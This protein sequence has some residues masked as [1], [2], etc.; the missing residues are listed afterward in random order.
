MDLWTPSEED[1]ESFYSWTKKTDAW[2]Q[3]TKD[4]V[5]PPTLVNTSS[6]QSFLNSYRAPGNEYNV[7]NYLQLWLQLHKRDSNFFDSA[8]DDALDD[9]RVSIWRY[10]DSNG[11]P[12]KGI[13]SPSTNTYRL[14]YQYI[15]FAP[16]AWQVLLAEPAPPPAP[17]LTNN[18][19]KAL[20]AFAG[21]LEATQEFVPD[22]WS[23]PDIQMEPDNS[24]LEEKSW[25]KQKIW[26]RSLGETVAASRKALQT[27]LRP[28]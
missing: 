4:G 3:F 16:V 1:W 25:K 7:M 23:S 8:F 18:E 20:K 27:V 9:V 5:T 13:D 26:R 14:A 10:K 22:D 24:M 12:W 11:K 6:Q 21:G 28:R 15:C 2:N 19:L 17:A